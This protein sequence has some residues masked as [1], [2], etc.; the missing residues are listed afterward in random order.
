MSDGTKCVW[1]VR[2]YLV[3]ARVIC[4][5]IS[6]C[7]F[8]AYT[9]Y[10]Q[11]MWP[12][13]NK[14]WS[15]SAKVIQSAALLKCS[16]L[17]SPSPLKDGC[18]GCVC[19]RAFN[20]SCVCELW[21]NGNKFINHWPTMFALA[22]WASADKGTTTFIYCSLE[23]L[24]QHQRVINNIVAGRLKPPPDIDLNSVS[25][26]SVLHWTAYIFIRVSPTTYIIGNKWLIRFNQKHYVKNKDDERQDSWTQCKKAICEDCQDV[27]S[28]Q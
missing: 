24:L 17:L 25:F 12:W 14:K 19:N 18:G 21:P 11:I 4:M 13:C 3:V 27:E 7:F 8:L 1:H 28:G 16:S 26:L 9:G 6:E 23:S 10:L 22:N 2:F 5:L 15:C 20:P